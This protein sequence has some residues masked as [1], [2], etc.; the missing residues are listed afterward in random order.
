MAAMPPSRANR[1]WNA[2]DD[3]R[4][5]PHC[6]EFIEIDKVLDKMPCF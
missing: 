6:R 5:T 4:T 2:R 3:C 1:N